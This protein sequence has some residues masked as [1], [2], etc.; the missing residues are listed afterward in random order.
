MLT[1]QP[2]LLLFGQAM[3]MDH[4]AINQ[5][6]QNVIG[7]FSLFFS[8]VAIV[9]LVQLVANNSKYFE[10]IVPTRLILAFVIATVSYL[11]H[12][13]ILHND[14]VFVL[15]FLEIWFNFLIYNVLRQEKV[16]RTNKLKERFAKEL[17]EAEQDSEKYDELVAKFE[18]STNAF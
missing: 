15:S 14:F 10:S 16:A 4:G 17:L 6:N 5:H 11:K 12:D 8:S 9:D 1:E 7:L 3:E 13:S 18:R 2:L